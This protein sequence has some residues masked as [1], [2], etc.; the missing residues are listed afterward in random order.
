MS[1]IVVPSSS[2]TTEK[3]IDEYYD[4]TSDNS[5]DN[6]SHSNEGSSS[7]EGYTSGVPGLPLEV[8][9]EQLRKASGSQA[10]VSSN[11]PPSS[12]LDEEETVYSCAVGIHSK[13]SEQRLSNLRTWYQIPDKFNPRL[14]IRGEWYC[15]PRFG[16][17]VYEAY[18]LGGFRLPLNTFARELL[19]D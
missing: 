4:S 14:P 1:E 6:N 11:V 3:A 15:N 5:S 19:F 16:I 18:F 10:G 13:T 2:D 9:Q 17:G 8:V 12:P 7:N